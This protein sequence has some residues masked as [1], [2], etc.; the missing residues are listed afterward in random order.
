MKIR[1]L[2]P[3]LSVCLGTALL[4]WSVLPSAAAELTVETLM[5]DRSLWPSRV[6]TN[7][8][9]T[10]QVIN[11]NLEAKGFRD[12]KKGE[13]VPL[14]AISG[15]TIDVRVPGGTAVLFTEDTDLLER[16]IYKQKHGR[17]KA[18]PKPK[19]KPKPK[20][21][22]TPTSKMG[23]RLMGR[24]VQTQGGQLKAIPKGDQKDAKYYAFYHSAEWC[25]PCRAFTPKLVD[26][27]N[28]KLKKN[29]NVELVFLSADRSQSAMQNYLKG[30]RMPWP[31]IRYNDRSLFNDVRD[32]CGRG[33]PGLVL[34]DSQGKVVAQGRNAVMNR[35]QQF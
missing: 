22:S 19:P 3:A 1:D 27:Y 24:L 7:K 18:V 10:V 9:L 23:Q 5:E 25:P 16:A 29:P 15:S 26:L 34:Y 28:R 17:E 32:R 13:V 35:L 6:T 2:F 20:S 31:A 33:I 8:P 12:L 11:A 30:Y 14:A 4:A 21:A